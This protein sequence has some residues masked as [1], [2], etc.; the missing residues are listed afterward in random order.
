MNLLKPNPAPLTLLPVELLELVPL[1]TDDN[2]LGILARL[3]GRLADGEVRLDRL[4]RDRSVVGKIEPDLRLGDL[5][6]V[7][8]DSGLLAQKVVGNGDGRGFT[9]VSGVL[10]EGPSED[11][12]LLTGDGV[13]EGVDDLS[14]ESVLLVL[15]LRSAWF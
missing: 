5:R 8:G 15:V 7:D 9:R 10:L 3:E 2:R 6:V 4:G 1:G 13:E 14:G 12:N 11:G